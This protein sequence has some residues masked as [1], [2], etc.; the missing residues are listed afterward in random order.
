MLS[1]LGMLIMI[2][3]DYIMIDMPCY[4]GKLIVEC[5]NKFIDRVNP[6]TT[7]A[8]SIQELK[9]LNADMRRHF[10]TAIAKL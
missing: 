5:H 6:C 8:F 7:D 2:Y 1:H 4:I 10:H 3:Q 9:P